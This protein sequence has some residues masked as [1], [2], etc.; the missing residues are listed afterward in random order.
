VIAA[1]LLIAAVVGGAVVTV[2]R[3]NAAPPAPTLSVEVP[4]TFVPVAGP[5]PPVHQPPQ[6]SL[7]LQGMDRDIALL[8]ADTPHPI[9][10][11][12]KALTAYE[13]LR[14][15]PLADQFDEG[16]VLTMT[17]VDVADYQRTI[18][19]DG[20]SLPVVAGERLT[21]RQMLLGLLL[22]SANNFADSLGRWVAG[23]V[24]QFV[25]ELN[26]RARELGMA[27][28]HFVDPSG[29]S[30]ETVSSASDLV[31]L[32]RKV[33]GVPALAAI[34][35]TQ[36][37]ELPDGTELDNLDTLLGSE[38]G[39]LGIKTGN[40]EQ[41]GGCLLFAAR[42]P[43][44]GG[45]VT[46]VGAVLGQTDLD[47]A[48]DAAKTA[49][50]SGYLGYGVVRFTDVPPLSGGVST[51]WG[52][53]SA[54]FIPTGG[55]DRGGMPVRMGTV[56]HLGVVLRP[57]AA[58]SSANATVAEVDG[59]DGVEARFHWAVALAAEIRPPSFWWMLFKN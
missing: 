48:L 21:E 6:G 57:V 37:A 23:S 28:T 12:A 58:R 32:G 1:V 47:A 7:A 54:L 2:V 59:D 15:H 9:A 3:V 46:M 33:L 10:S 8:D 30:P 52:D 34:V 11:V 45:V 31:I 16:P 18:R 56:L 39:W 20:S 14:V 43:V 35:A 51:R 49:V 42:R 27:H 19:N 22:P 38:P 4:S 29:F 13:V 24:D 25:A 53:R 50:D 36:H 40:T 55:D 26:Q 41:A 5:P 17:D 44:G